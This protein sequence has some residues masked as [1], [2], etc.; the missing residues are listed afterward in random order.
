MLKCGSFVGCKMVP[1][2]R[3]PIIPQNSFADKKTIYIFAA[4]NRTTNPKIETTM[5]NNSNNG[6][7]VMNN[8]K[9]ASRKMKQKA[10]Q[11]RIQAEA[12][13]RRKVAKSWELVARGI[14]YRKAAA[15]ESCGRLTQI[16]EGELFDGILLNLKG[17]NGMKSYA[18]QKRILRR[19]VEKRQA[20]SAHRRAGRSGNRFTKQLQHYCASQS[21]DHLKRY[22][23]CA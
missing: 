8:T 4:Q 5:K 9:K 23:L 11:K 3:E 16:L 7:K 6:Q 12:N 14:K 17:R 10:N 18:C 19:I 21:L 13:A 2:Y 22:Q 1:S 15:K 20:Q